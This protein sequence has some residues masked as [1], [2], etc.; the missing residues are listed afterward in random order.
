MHRL[1]ICL[2][3][4][5][6][7]LAACGGGEDPGSFPVKIS[8]EVR[9]DGTT[10]FRR[11]NGAEPGTLD[12]HQARGVPAANILRD[13]YAGLVSV[14]PSGDLEPGDAESWQVSDD[15]R[16]YTF[17]L[18]ADAKWSNGK[19]VTATDY[20]YSLR[21]GVDPATAS[22]YAQLH[23]PIV[24]AIAIIAGDKAPDTLGVKALDTRHLQITL[25][26]PTPYFLGTLAHASSYPV[27][28]PAVEQY[29]DTFSQPGH[30][31]TNGAYK[32][33]SWRVN[34]MIAITRNDQYW[35]NA[36][37]A[38]DRV[39]YYPIADANSELSRYQAGELDWAGVIPP[40]RLETVQKYI[41]AQFKAV[42]TLGVYYYGLNLRHAPFKDAPRLRQALSMA[43]DRQVIVDKITRGNEVPAYGWIPPAVEGYDG[44]KFAWA[45]LSDADR[46]AR[47]KKLYAEAGYSRDKPLQVEIR[48]NSNEGNKKIA[49]VIS[50]MWRGV[51]GADV[52][53]RNEE[54]KVYLNSVRQGSDTEAFRM[55][56]IGDYDDPNTFFELMHSA[57][58]LNG[59]TY[60]S[61]TYDALQ[62]QQAHM[63]D[64]SERDAVMHKAEATLLADNPVIP[65]YF[66]TSKYLVKPYVK[67]FVGN[68]L[69]I[70]Y[71]KDLRIEP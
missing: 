45:D 20:V 5:C 60:A 67:G 37:T 8:P 55:A 36:N 32:M 65:I 4:A 14:S 19:P 24:N 44:P 56:W 49:S 21:R 34:S 30:A 16:V 46:E 6:A 38:I 48:Y 39:E 42:P 18:R 12:P 17:T 70:Y 33:D 9:A 52:T 59:T 47:A 27:Y 64:G 22:P 62:E 68:A 25:K 61:R 2:I 57:F 69:D 29:G 15:K 53:L 41:P 31:V 28:R 71:S 1:L 40:S 35:D 63:P 7:G 54:W 3:L 23:A 66:Y 50:A 11:G 51:L 43:I 13:L 10:V 26:K 58:G